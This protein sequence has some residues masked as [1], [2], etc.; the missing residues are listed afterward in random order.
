MNKQSKKS[1]SFIRIFKSMEKAVIPYMI[2][3]FILALMSMLIQ[4]LIA[5]MFKDM[6]DAIAKEQLDDMFDTIKFYGIIVVTIFAINPLFAYMAQKSAAITT[7]NIRNALFLKMERLPVSFFKKHHSGDLVS[8]LTNDTVEVEKSYS[9]YFI[10]FAFQIMTGI[11]TTIYMFYI[12][13]RLATF[14]LIGGLITL[15]INVFYSKILRHISGE[16]QQKLSNLTER[17]TNLLGGVHVIRS[18]NLQAVILGKFINKNDDVYQTSLKRVKHQSVISALNTFVGLISFIGIATAGSYLA[19]NGQISVG[20]IVAVVQLQNGINGL[21]RT[22]GPF[23]TQLQSSLA[24]ADRIFEVIDED[25]EPEQYKLPYKNRVREGVK[26]SDDAIVFHNVEF[27]YEDDP[28]AKI[29][30]QL[31]LSVSKGKVYALAGPSGGGKS[32]LFKL[33]LNFYPPNNGTIMIDGKC[34]SEH[35]IKDI[36]TNIAYVPQ[37]AYLFSGSIRDNIAYGK[38]GATYDEIKQAAKLA[39]ASKFI[40]QMEDGYET[41]VGERGADLSGGQRQRIAIARAILKDAPILLLDEATS[42]LDTES[43]SL[44]QDALNKLMVGRTTLVIAHRLST[45]QGADQILVLAEGRI[46]EQGTHQELINM[47]TGIYQTLYNKQFK[48]T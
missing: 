27:S 23:V 10:N 14:A 41:L 21:V 8:R 29:L 9:Q 48:Q 3:L 47:K 12:E 17:L 28:A 7:G 43:E 42:A 16:V 13:W 36:R 15:F 37:D 31:S 11:G 1:S 35:K 2:G 5:T 26:T 22:L 18:F 40:E 44:V 38:K 25:E 34:I 24:A 4:I 6:F 46:V 30:D 45:I 32:T 39:N 20:V 33:L 19:I